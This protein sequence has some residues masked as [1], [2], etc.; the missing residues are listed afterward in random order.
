MIG[1]VMTADVTVDVTVD[2]YTV[3]VIVCYC[4]YYIG[5]RSAKLGISV[6]RNQHIV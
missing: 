6:A 4:R 5:V 1:F 3:D 2:V